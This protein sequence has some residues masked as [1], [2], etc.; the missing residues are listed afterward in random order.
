[1][2]ILESILRKNEGLYALCEANSDLLPKLA[3][4]C[5]DLVSLQL[6]YGRLITQLLLVSLIPNQFST[7]VLCIC[8]NC[9]D[10]HPCHSTRFFS[11]ACSSYC[12]MPHSTLPKQEVIYVSLLYPFGEIEIL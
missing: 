7:K 9:L 8:L 1:M 11:S 4:I 5:G 12:P 2:T 10:F 3:K 6:L